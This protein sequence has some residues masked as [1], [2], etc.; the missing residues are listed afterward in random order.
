[1]DTLDSLTK[2]KGKPS[3]SFP[4]IISLF[5]F[6]PGVTRTRGPRIRNPVLYP[7]E[8]RGHKE[9]QLVTVNFFFLRVKLC[10]SVPNGFE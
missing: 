8:L 10:Q 4:F 3:I 1:L 9:Y 7:P 6:A 2:E 5:R